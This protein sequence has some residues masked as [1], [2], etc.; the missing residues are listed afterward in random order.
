MSKNLIRG[1]SGF[2]VHVYGPI[3]LVYRRAV[4]PAKQQPQLV[5]I[6]PDNRESF[7]REGNRLTYLHL[8]NFVLCGFSFHLFYI[9]AVD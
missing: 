6:G 1:V 2:P 4:S 9:F 5:G 7:Y 3:L 8:L